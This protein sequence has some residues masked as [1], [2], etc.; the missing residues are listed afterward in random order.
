MALIF[1]GKDGS[2]KDEQSRKYI[3]EVLNDISEGWNSEERITISKNNEFVFQYTTYDKYIEIYPTNHNNNDKLI[4]IH[5]VKKIAKLKN[6]AIGYHTFYIRGLERCSTKA[7]SALSSVLRTSSNIWVVGTT[8]QPCRVIRCLLPN[9]N[10][11]PCP[12]IYDM[13]REKISDTI[14][15]PLY[16]LC[17]HVIEKLQKKKDPV[18]AHIFIRESVYKLSLVYQPGNTGIIVR[19]MH[20]NMMVLL[21]KMN[22]KGQIVP[23]TQYACEADMCIREANRDFYHLELFFLRIYAILAEMFSIV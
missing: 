11:V 12:Q 1:H 14:G 10:S 20:E 9:V 15:D 13:C 2:K 5:F 8:N 22:E 16:N 17:Y 21:E 7:L 4:F 19:K 6:I 18:D 23:L 3:Q